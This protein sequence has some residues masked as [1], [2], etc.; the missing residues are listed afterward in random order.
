M[1]PH[2]RRIAALFAASLKNPVS[3]YVVG[4]AIRA[5]VENNSWQLRYPVG[6][7][8]APLLAWRASMTDEQWIDSV[9]VTDEE[10]AARVKRDF[11]LDVV[12]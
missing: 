8:A 5:I 6:P 11:G 7:D 9:A 2:S 12:L 4:E 10:W 3:P 1:Y